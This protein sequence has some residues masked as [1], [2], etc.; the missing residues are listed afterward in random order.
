MYRGNIIEQGSVKDIFS[1]PQQ[2]Y[3]KALIACRPVNHQR[4]P[5]C[6]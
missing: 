2:P 6:Q 4:G 1:N 5:D 3:T